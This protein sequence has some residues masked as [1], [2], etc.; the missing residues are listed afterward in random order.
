MINFKSTLL[1]ATAAAMV[2]LTGCAPAPYYVE[3]EVVLV[4]VHIPVPY[5]VPRPVPVVAYHP[6]GGAVPVS[7]NE[8]L[9]RQ[10]AETVVKTKTQER[11]P[12]DQVVTTRP[13]TVAPTENNT[14]STVV[15]TK[16]RTR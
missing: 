9:E 5:P 12:A 4:P 7:R 15:R 3:Q 16:T 11:Q 1:I 13:R 14:A 10:P 2:I 8:P 6:V